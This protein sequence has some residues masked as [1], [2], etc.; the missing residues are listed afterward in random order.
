MSAIQNSPRY[1]GKELNVLEQ[2]S[3]V[4]WYLKVP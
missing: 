1:I 3:L 4:S 2:I